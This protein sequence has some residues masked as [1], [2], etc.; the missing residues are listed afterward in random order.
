MA[1]K[2]IMWGDGTTDKI[3]VTYSGAVGSSSVSVVS[4]PNRTLSERTKI[5]S[6][7]INGATKGTLKVTQKARMRAYS[8][9][10]E[11]SYK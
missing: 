9:A 11:K 6:L 7:K 3:T 4:D 5:I 8:K 10:Y 2:T 1:A